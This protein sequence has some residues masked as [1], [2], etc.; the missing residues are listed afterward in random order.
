MATDP[1]VVDNR[2]DTKQNK[3]SSF[4]QVE[5]VMGMKCY[6]MI[7]VEDELV[8]INNSLFEHLSSIDTFTNDDFTSLFLEFNTFYCDNESVFYDFDGP[9]S[10]I[11]DDLSRFNMDMEYTMN[12]HIGD[13]MV[14]QEWLELFCFWIFK[15]YICDDFTNE[16]H[17]SQLNLLCYFI[18]HFK[19]YSELSKYY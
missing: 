7:Q 12:Q 10:S 19:H 5:E 17:I 2:K 6:G 11:M 4:R 16:L 1:L 15:Y 14:E 3:T 13:N 8:Y 18:Y 9:L